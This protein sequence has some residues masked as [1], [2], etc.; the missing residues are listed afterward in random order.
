MGEILFPKYRGKLFEDKDL[1][2]QKIGE[3]GPRKAQPCVYQMV[4]GFCH[5]LMRLAHWDVPRVP[6]N[7]GHICL[8]LLVFWLKLVLLAQTQEKL[9]L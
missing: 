1:K 4:Y 7:S 6:K 2:R 8:F 5:T 3:I 9:S